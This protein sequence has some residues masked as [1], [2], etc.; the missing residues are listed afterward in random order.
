MEQKPNIRWPRLGTKPHIKI[1]GLRR[2]EDAVLAVDLGASFLGIILTSQSPR[3]LSLSDA[4]ALT[5]GL[6]AR[7]PDSKLRFIGVFVDEAPEE[8]AEAQHRLGL[9]AVQVHGPLP[10]GGIALAAVIPA[11]RI[12]SQETANSIDN[13][14]QDHPAVLCDAFHEGL[15]G[16]TGKTFDHELVAPYFEKR[17]VFVAGGINPDNIAGMVTSLCD[18]GSLPYAFDLSSGVEQAPGVKD[19]AKLRRFFEN[20]NRSFGDLRAS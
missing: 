9:A 5:S 11:L 4:E 3:H 2:L 8:I 6:R 13:L 7:F 14:P 16:G 20:Y 17:R 19:H 10:G 1:C 18:A 15:H 12:R